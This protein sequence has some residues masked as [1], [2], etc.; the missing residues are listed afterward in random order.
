MQKNLFLLLW[1]NS[2]RL[3]SL[4]IISV[5]WSERRQSNSELRGIASAGSPVNLEMDSGYA[6]A[7][8]ATFM[9]FAFVRT[10]PLPVRPVFNFMQKAKEGRQVVSF[11]CY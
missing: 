10:R 11:S 6:A 5:I 3:P 1:T 9:I 8:G 4:T 7:A 2:M